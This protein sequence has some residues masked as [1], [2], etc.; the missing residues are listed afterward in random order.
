MGM[1]IERFTY[2]R[3]AKTRFI[4]IDNRLHILYCTTETE[5]RAKNITGLLNIK[6]E[7]QTL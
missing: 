6:A 4:V 1:R 5:D 3:V 7:G 2:I